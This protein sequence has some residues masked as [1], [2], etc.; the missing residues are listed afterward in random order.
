MKLFRNPRNSHGRNDL[1]TD[2]RK[3]GT[4]LDTHTDDSQLFDVATLRRRCVPCLVEFEDEVQGP[5][6]PLKAPKRRPRT[7]AIP[8]GVGVLAGSLIISGLLDSQK[9]SPL[10]QT[11][12]LEVPINPQGPE[13]LFPSTLPKGMCPFLSSATGPATDG[14]H[15]LNRGSLTLSR[16][17]QAISFFA[18]M[19]TVDTVVAEPI[20]V[21]V[22][23]GLMFTK[24]SEAF[25]T[26]T[27]DVANPGPMN[28]TAVYK[29][30]SGS[31][32]LRLAST[33]SIIPSQPNGEDVNGFAVRSSDTSWRA[34]T[35][36]FLEPRNSSNVVLREC[37]AWPTRTGL[38]PGPRLQISTRTFAAGV[39]D[40]EILE[41][42]T[43]SI[44][45]KRGDRNVD[46]LRIKRGETISFMWREGN[47]KVWANG[48]GVSDADIRVFVASLEAAS[49][50]QVNGAQ[51]PKIPPYAESTARPI[52]S[53]APQPL[54]ESLNERLGTNML[55]GPAEGDVLCLTLDS[56][57]ILGPDGNQ[58]DESCSDEMRYENGEVNAVFGLRGDGDTLMAL[59]GVFVDSDKVSKV[60]AV[61]SDGSNENFVEVI[62]SRVSRTHA[63][64][65]VQKRDKPFPKSIVFLGSDG[66]VVRTQG[67]GG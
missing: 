35:T 33:I 19:L 32:A 26:W 24:G 23:N 66:K 46:A 16:G 14:V 20:L 45:L 7:F 51:D 41:G 6:W 39:V 44:N 18:N 50:E 56:Q 42:G 13:F 49:A 25:I 55:S 61:F 60:V 57:S 36:S 48:N 38:L 1:H 28:M 34:S 40:F 27:I 58:P 64:L 17:E 8:I 11:N 54:A 4:E 12:A 21:G 30:M 2:L 59:N 37:D 43:E 65:R 63:F 52:R 31:E 15:G 9:S 67:S 22:H 53:L 62:D 29:R 10:V 47:T 3:L 5:V